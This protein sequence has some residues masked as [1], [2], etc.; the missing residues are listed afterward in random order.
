V[1]YRVFLAGRR[2]TQAHSEFHGNKPDM[3]AR[4]KGDAAESK[5]SMNREISGPAK[6]DLV[7]K[8]LDRVTSVVR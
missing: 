8:D 1:D 2:S 4:D 5:A 7:V 6:E 3:K